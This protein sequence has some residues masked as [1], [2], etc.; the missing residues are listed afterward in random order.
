MF[1]RLVYKARRAAFRFGAGKVVY[2]GDHKAICTTIFGHKI[3]LD[4]RDRSVAPH[5]LIDGAWELHLSLVLHG[6]IKPGGV[7]VDIGANVGWYSL[8]AA[9]WLGDNG[10]VHAFEANPEIASLLKY[11]SVINGYSD[12]VF[13]EPKA[14]SNFVGRV[15]FSVD[16]DFYGNSSVLGQCDY[17]V[18]GSG[19]GALIEVPVV[20]L[21][22]YFSHSDR[23]DL[24]K[25]DAEGSEPN[26][27]KGA[28]RVLDDNRDIVLVLEV[29]ERST[30]E[31][32]AE[33]IK[34]L[35]QIGFRAWS[36]DV[37]RWR[38][39][40]LSMSDLIKGKIEFGS[41]DIVFRR[42]NQRVERCA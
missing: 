27:I 40:A 4:T 5:L 23:V 15:A 33:M 38:L 34:T 25:C 16:R 3:L 29:N 32:R 35:N 26:I 42:A 8:L 1:D 18:E 30:V 19:A 12:R 14:V 10:V 9:K 13:V 2:L 39:V 21:D 41:P 37:R 24:I 22:D 36:V 20:S 31:A 7:V 11:S 28:L 17:G 6:L